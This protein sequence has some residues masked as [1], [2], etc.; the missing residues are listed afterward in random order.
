LLTGLNTLLRRLWPRVALSS[1]DLIAVYLMLSLQTGLGSMNFIHWLMGSITYG[2][3]AANPN[4]RW[5]EEYLIHLPDWLM[6]TDREALKGYYMGHSRFFAE[7]H[8]RVWLVPV[9][10]W[11]LYFWTLAAVLLAVAVLFSR[12]W[13][14]RER[15]S[16]PEVE[17]P[18][19]MVSEGTSFWRQRLMWYGFALAA[20]AELINGLNFLYPSIPRLPL[21]RLNLAP[22]LTDPPWNA[23]GETNISF[24]PFIIGLT[25]LI[26]LDLSMSLWVFYLLH[27]AQ[28]LFGAMVGWREIPGY[29]FPYQQQFGAGAA[30]IVVALW[31]SRD[32]L[33]RVWRV[34]WAPP[35]RSGEGSD[36]DPEERR[37]Y[38][39]C[40]VTIA[41]GSVLIPAFMAAAG[42]TW[43]MGF[44]V[45]ALY[46]FM[47]LVVSRIRC[48]LGFSLHQM[49]R[50]NGPQIL[51]LSMGSQELGMK[52]VTL[53]GLFNS[54]T[55]NNQSHIMPHQFEGLKM[56]DRENVRPGGIITAMAAAIL[57]AVP[58]TF[59][60]YLASTYRFGAG[61]GHMLYG[62]SGYQTYGQ[63]LQS[64]AHSDTY[65]RP[66]GMALSVTAGSF[67]VS[68]L[69]MMLRLR[70]IGWP[71][72]PIGLAVANSNHDITDVWVPVLFASV[73]K[74][75]I[76][77]YSGLRGYR[78]LL[79]FF[80]GIIL[81]DLV[82]GMTWIA[83]AILFNTPMYQFFL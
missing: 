31:S 48:E 45:Y 30:I 51:V 24:Y 22:L 12:Q 32:H 10:W 68:Y 2:P 72:H 25:Y 39:Q 8:W 53:L 78:H 58:A 4:N 54:F 49:P 61:T 18:F 15:M 6:I 27:K 36:T 1:A 26:P 34:A 81:G 80:L 62:L 20:G 77:R 29:P 47:G 3:W 55:T 59:L 76:L 14:R 9:I 60:I 19:Q 67:I 69:L 46:V 79:P 50:M 37:Q 64:W 56:A 28:L 73:L 43:W 83:I 52:N 33:R 44:V 57:I 13:I 82:M 21:K 75:V 11:T 74:G 71:L 38:R 35:L 16:F 41:A 63:F 17:L 70:F 7:G 40:L 65:E 42:L 5:A 23:L 66:Y